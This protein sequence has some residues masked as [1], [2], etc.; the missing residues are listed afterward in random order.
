MTMQTLTVTRAPAPATM[1]D[2]EKTVEAL[3]PQYRGM[4]YRFYQRHSAD[5][6]PVAAN[7]W[8]HRELISRFGVQATLDASKDI[9]RRAH[10]ARRGVLAGLGK[11]VAQ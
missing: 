2:L 8:L 4:C 10:V 7:R 9:A 3:L 6:L 11:A 1:T 5:A